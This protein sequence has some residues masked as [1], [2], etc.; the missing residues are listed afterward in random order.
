MYSKEEARQ[1][2]HDFWEGFDRYTKFFSKKTGESISW[3]LYKTGIKGL[4]MKFYIEKKLMQV[5]IEVNHK[6]ENR[7]FDIYVE[8]NKYKNILENGLETE[9]FW[10]DDMQID[11][12][13]VVSRVFV[14]TDAY[15]FHR[16]DDWP[17]I[18]KFMAT[19]MFQIQSNFLDIHDILKEKFGVN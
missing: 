16:R 11:E 10:V 2:K 9:V 15:N 3:V 19:N 13:K 17:E 1:L 14:E 7:R 18:Y 8:L 6:S 4:E 12:N 5:M